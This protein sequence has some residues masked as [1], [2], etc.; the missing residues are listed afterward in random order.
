M[1][2]VVPLTLLLL[3]GCGNAFGVL[4][5]RGPIAAHIHEL[6]WLLFLLALLVFA[7]V[8][9]LL[10]YALFHSRAKESAPR[11]D[12]ERRLV[13][14]GGLV[15]PI[16]VLS[17]MFVLTIRSTVELSKQPTT[18]LTIQVIGHQWWWEIRYVDYGFDTA[19]EITIPTEKNV[20]VELQTRDVIHSFWLPELS[21]KVDLVPGHTN[22]VWLNAKEAG[23]YQGYCAEFCGLQHALM[24]FQVIAL[25]SDEFENWAR[26]QQRNAL[27]PPDALA[28]RG[29]QIFLTEECATCHVVRG[30]N[31][32]GGKGPDLT[33][34][35]SRRTLAAGA[36]KNTRDALAQWIREPEKIKRGTT[37]PPT[38]LSD[39]DLQALHAYMESL[40]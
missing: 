6:W 22:A 19:N 18:D 33:H 30:T 5:P 38:L 26:A 4:N 25:R 7:P 20:R 16:V 23:V 14:G 34:F 11:R 24:K 3:L 21:G 32:Q 13:V 2:R 39:A 28:Q 1:S 12:V 37:M 9:A 27:P 29:L 8:L 31:A 17:A 40:K 10:L 15:M 36:V 35:A